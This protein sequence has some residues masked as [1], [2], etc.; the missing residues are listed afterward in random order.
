MEVILKA[1]EDLRDSSLMQLK[2]H[3]TNSA[4]EHFLFWAAW[5]LTVS[6]IIF[7]F[8]FLFLIFSLCFSKRP[9]SLPEKVTGLAK[10][11]KACF[12]I[13]PRWTPPHSPVDQIWST[14]YLYYFS[15]HP[16]GCLKLA[17]YGCA[18]CVPHGVPSWEWNGAEQLPGFSSPNAMALL[19]HSE[20]GVLWCTYILWGDSGPSS[21]LF[22]ECD[23][24]LFLPTGLL[25]CLHVSA[26][27]IRPALL[28]FC[29]TGA[30]N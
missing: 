20:E 15:S 13:S 25:L 5:E 11:I 17:V 2:N 10:I 1:T 18:H 4:R 27:R 7:T 24:L 8:T 28:S 6:P 23:V 22:W 21:L 14:S 3:K 9:L 16:T 26:P 12:P 30:W 19:V 29:I